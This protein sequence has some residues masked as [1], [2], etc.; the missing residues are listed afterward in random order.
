MGVTNALVFDPGSIPYVVFT[1]V[2]L[3][4]VAIAMLVRGDPLIR[5]AVITSTFLCLP[6]AGGTAVLLNTTDPHLA[7]DVGRFF[8][9]SWSI[10][11]P[12][13]L[14][15][16]LS[17]AGVID[18]HRPLLIATGVVGAI[19]CAVTWSTDLVVS[20]VWDLPWGTWYPA[21]G[22]LFLPHVGILAFGITT[23]VFF[24]VHGMRRRRP[25][26]RVREGIAAALFVAMGTVD[27]LLM[28]YG[29]GVYPWAVVPGVIGASFVI[30]T[31]IK[32]DLLRARGLDRAAA[33]ELGMLALLVP[34]TITV[35]WAA[36]PDGLGGGAE[37]AVVMLLPL[38]GGA[39]A[40]ALMLRAH[41]AEQRAVMPPEVER[42]VE[43]FVEDCAD[44]RDHRELAQA[45]IELVE[46]GTS[47]ARTSLLV[48]GAGHVLTAVDQGA[49]RTWRLD[50]PL[51]AWLVRHHEPLVGGELSS[52]RLGALREPVEDLLA[53]LDRDILVPLVDRDTLVGVIAAA[54]GSEGRALS[55]AELRLLSEAGRAAAKALTFIALFREA[56]ARLEI[57]K[58]LEVAAAVQHAR[59]PG[60]VRHEFAACQVVGHY[61]PAVQF[62][63]DWWT[64]HELPDDRVLVVLGDVTGRG[65]P[66][67]LVSSTAVAACQTAQTLLGASCEV[68]SLLELL[69]DAVLTVGGSRYGMS[70]CV[71][72][73]DRDDRRVTVANAGYP[74]PY[75]CRPAGPD[76]RAELKPLISRGTV[77][78]SREP[79]FNAVTAPFE[80]GDVVVLASDALAAVRNPEG[81]PY[82]ERRLQQVL[83]R[84]VVPAEERACKVIFDDVLTHCGG[85]QPEDDLT[86]VVVRAPARR[87][88]P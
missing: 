76:G 16:V 70:C 22:P 44:L 56:E 42:A 40:A 30:V 43:Q 81:R 41:Q 54:P 52:L 15:F 60:E 35:T 5:A 27:G 1:A 59:S 61:Q 14:L 37:M 24:A 4:L 87:R 18:R 13:V 47:L 25:T 71:A 57:A 9:G 32:S 63:G 67:A 78:G 58:E 6:W 65:V 19:S 55:D 20:G 8:V 49:A 80:D 45:L 82:G 66:A 85:G 23:G 88:P 11:A 3:A 39:Q 26:L 48:A 7:V 84:Y 36:R 33:Y 12:G 83:E 53:E 31:V 74:F 28:G 79:V 75:L 38:F 17:T 62:G 21:A 51:A 64:A 69:N 2:L 50:E 77:L 10:L 72:L 46:L 86:V 73:F 34:L 68:L 29:I